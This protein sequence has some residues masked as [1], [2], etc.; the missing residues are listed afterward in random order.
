MNRKLSALI[1]VHRHVMHNSS[2]NIHASIVWLHSYKRFCADTAHW[3]ATMRA[4]QGYTGC[5]SFD[6]IPLAACTRSIANS[7]LLSNVAAAYIQVLVL[8]FGCHRLDQLSSV[9]KLVKN[10]MHASTSLPIA[11]SKFLHVGWW[12]MNYSNP[13]HTAKFLSNCGLTYLQLCTCSK[14]IRFRGLMSAWATDSTGL[15]P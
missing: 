15:L 5:E 14:S 1:C 4:N 2:E 12:Y 3:Y 9:R 6:V 7:D 13:P 10:Q 8:C 11:T